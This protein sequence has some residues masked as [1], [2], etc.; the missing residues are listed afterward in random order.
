[1]RARTNLASVG[2]VICLLA[3]TTHAAR[4]CSSERPTFEDAV[5]S[6]TSIARVT[7]TDRWEYGDTEVGETHRVVETLKGSVTETVHLEDPRGSLCGDHVADFV[8]EAPEAI[9]AYGVP[10]YDQVLSIAWA[11]SQE[12]VSL[13]Y[14]LRPMTGSTELPTTITDLDE[15][16]AAI[17]ALLPDTALEPPS[18]ASTT[19]LGWMLFLAAL[20]TAYVR[21]AARESPGTARASESAPDRSARRGGHRR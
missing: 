9:V 3:T 6:A 20:A 21:V 4:A 1:M 10:F 2:L 18:P 19:V 15:L 16:E 5:R 12:A 13:E 8:G 17:R 14:G 7:I 11:E